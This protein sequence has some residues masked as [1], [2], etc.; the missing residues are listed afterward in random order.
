MK[1]IHN[2]TVCNKCGRNGFCITKNKLANMNRYRTSHYKIPVFSIKIIKS[3]TSHLSINIEIVSNRFVLLFN[4]FF[5]F[6]EKG[7][8]ENP[9]STILLNNEKREQEMDQEKKKHTQKTTSYREFS[10]K[11]TLSLQTLLNLSICNFSMT[12]KLPFQ[13]GKKGSYS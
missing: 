1:R 11:D 12:L 10:H 5:F 8:R 6:E 7:C 13:K 9:Y 3:T 2:F 4:F